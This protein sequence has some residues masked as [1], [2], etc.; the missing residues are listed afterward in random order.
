MYIVGGLIDMDMDLAQRVY[1][2]LGL[3]RS[4]I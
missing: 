2:V 4:K 3:F 1:D